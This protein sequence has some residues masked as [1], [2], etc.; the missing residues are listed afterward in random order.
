MCL[1]VIFMMDKDDPVVA[2]MAARGL[3]SWNI[4]VSYENLFYLFLFQEFIY[5]SILT[6][7]CAI[8]FWLAFGY[9]SHVPPSGH[10]AGYMFTGVG[11]Q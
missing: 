5:S 2:S 6:I 7:L 4:I 9:A 11:P 3:L 1:Q 8:S 10:S